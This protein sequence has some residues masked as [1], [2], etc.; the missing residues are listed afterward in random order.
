MPN[1]GTKIKSKP[2]FAFPNALTVSCITIIPTCVTSI[3]FHMPVIDDRILIALAS[4]PCAATL[5]QLALS[6][7]VSSLI[8]DKSAPCWTN[9]PNLRR[10]QLSLHIGQ[11]KTLGAISALPLQ[12]L[13]LRL[14]WAATFWQAMRS[15][16]SEDRFPQM[17][18]L[19]LSVA[20]NAG[21][22]S[23]AGRDLLEV[24]RSRQNTFQM[25][26]LGLARGPIELSLDQ[27]RELQKL[28][29]RISLR[30]FTA[31][32]WW[33]NKA[34]RLLLAGVAQDD[35]PSSGSL[36]DMS[37][38]VKPRWLVTSLPSIEKLSADRVRN[39][40]F[41]AFRNLHTLDLNFAKKIVPLTHFPPL[42]RRLQ[43]TA[44]ECADPEDQAEASAA[45]W[46]LYDDLPIAVPRLESLYVYVRCLPKAGQVRKIVETL[47][48]LKSLNMVHTVPSYAGVVEE[49][50]ISHAALRAIPCIMVSNLVIK[51]VHLPCVSRFLTT[52]APP[53]DA[54]L[55]LPRLHTLSVQEKYKTE[56]SPIHQTFGSYESR[57]IDLH[58]ECHLRPTDLDGILSTFRG[59]CGLSIVASDLK[60]EAVE[61]IFAA[62]PHLLSFHFEP[63]Y[64]LHNLDFIK[65][66]R[67]STLRVVQRAPFQASK[68][69]PPSTLISFQ[70]E[71]LPN[72]RSL[73]VGGCRMKVKLKD[74]SQLTRFSVC[75]ADSGVSTE[76]RS[77]PAMATLVFS[78]CIVERLL[79]APCSESTIQITL[80]GELFPLLRPADDDDPSSNESEPFCV[81][82][83]G[84]IVTIYPHGDPS[85]GAA[86]MSERYPHS[87]HLFIER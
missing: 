83:Q 1:S 86:E 3:N 38:A 33:G 52:S 62:L 10:L 24:L 23:H 31:Q 20:E 49:L 74:L 35:L 50:Q 21:V 30:N 61:S 11:H 84:V 2:G 34:A 8:T 72:L 81:P 71:T 27:A 9:F 60:V 46:A 40:N 32:R 85:V 82:S 73:D 70:G 77:C 57:L 58:V 37:A 14:S 78:T 42:L 19:S 16:L 53:F 43:W 87:K 64:R 28:C 56:L 45:L 65:H 69:G 68:S 48:L 7:D 4:C 55:C 54:G 15:L 39:G 26:D 18:R 76:I 47:R 66:G 25:Q 44:E 12:E 22:D 41:Q 36:A 63:C 51:L 29:P 59:L 5:E 80:D 75:G 17:Q 6:T 13:E 67:L 79:L